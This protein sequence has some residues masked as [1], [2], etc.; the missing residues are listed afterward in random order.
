MI[1]FAAGVLT[2]LDWDSLYVSIQ[3]RL[4][5]LY[6]PPVASRMVWE[7]RGIYGVIIGSQYVK[8]QRS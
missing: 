5:S 3:L 4:D 7:C 2:A 8:I 6:L 1:H